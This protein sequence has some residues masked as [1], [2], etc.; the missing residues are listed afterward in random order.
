MHIIACA[1]AGGVGMLTF[2]SI[3]TPIQP[4]PFYATRTIRVTESGVG[5]GGAGWDLNVRFKYVQIAHPY[6]GN[7]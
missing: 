3:C 5:L 7:S 1:V 2:G 4:K 6:Q